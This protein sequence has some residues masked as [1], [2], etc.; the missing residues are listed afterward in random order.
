MLQDKSMLKNIVIH[1]RL[2]ADSNPNRIIRLAMYSISKE[3]INQLLQLDKMISDL[4]Q[5]APLF[6]IYNFH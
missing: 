2:T 4:Y 1:F 3:A 5:T 6:G